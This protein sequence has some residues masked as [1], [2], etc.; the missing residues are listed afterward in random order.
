MFEVNGN[1]RHNFFKGGRTV[2]Y[3][4]VENISNTNVMIFLDKFSIVDYF[5][6]MY[7]ELN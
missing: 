6:S 4:L 5:L 2:L 7:Q 3:E 1:D